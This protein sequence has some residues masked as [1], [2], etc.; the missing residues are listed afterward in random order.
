MGQEKVVSGHILSGLEVA[1]LEGDNF[2]EL[3]KTNTQECMSIHRG[4]N[5]RERDLLQWAHL[6]SV[7]LPE[8]DAEIELLIGTHVPKAL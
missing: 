3:P 7:H 5:Q 8:I 2:C 6:K 1:G 4:N